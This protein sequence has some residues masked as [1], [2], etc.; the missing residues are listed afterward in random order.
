[1]ARRI[2][3]ASQKGGVGKTTTVASIGVA[4]AEIGQ[5]VLLV[6]LDPQACLTF[7]MGIDPE[8]LSASVHDVMAGVRSAQDVIVATDEGVDLLPSTIDLAQSEATL[9]GKSNAVFTLQRALAMIDDEYDIVLLDCPPT[10][11]ILTVNA[12]T[13]AH[14]VLVPLQCETLAHRG[15][16]QV[17]ETVAEVQRVSNPDLV[18]LGFLPTMYD[19]RTTHAQA[20]LADI[21][22]RYDMPV[23][24]PPIPR[25]VRFA[26]A[27]ALGRTVL[28]TSPHLRGSE[29]Y[30]THA[31]QLVNRPDVC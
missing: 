14:E 4:L 6:D 16:G 11:G 10:L 29:V 31:R 1:M 18:V 22:T 28:S 13:A 24:T 9:V 23:L 12:L 7:S 30:R 3:V 25:S 5:R 2:A 15:V 19:G 26:E 27:P 21:G 20:V 17:I 8:N